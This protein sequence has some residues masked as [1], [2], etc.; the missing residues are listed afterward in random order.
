ML[1]SFADRP[2][3]DILAVEGYHALSR[4]SKTCDS[5]DQF[6]LAVPSYPGDAQDFACP[7]PFVKKKI[8]IFF[9][10]H[11]KNSNLGTTFAV[12]DLYLTFLLNNTL[13]III[14]GLIKP[15]N[16]FLYHY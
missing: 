2:T 15:N 4:A 5:L 11:K 10:K 7:N 16:L 8:Y 9:T 13:C 14:L 1:A 3:G 12:T 6:I